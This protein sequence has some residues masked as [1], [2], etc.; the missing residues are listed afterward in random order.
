MISTV[1]IKG[2]I[3]HTL[4]K[5]DAT[6]DDF[7][8]LLQEAIDSQMSYVCVPGTR[9]QQAISMAKEST[10]KVAAV[11]GFPHGNQLDGVKAF[12]TSSLVKLGVMEIDMVIDIGRLKE[13]DYK[14]VL[15]DIK[16]V[17]LAA[18]EQG[19]D[20]IIKV[21]I[22]TCLLT[23]EQIIDACILS[24]L[25]GADYVKTSTGF[26]SGGAK[27]EDIVLMK[28]VVGDKLLVK[29]SGGIKTY[30]DAI[31]MLQSGASRIGT[32]S[33]LTIINK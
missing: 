31:N 21:I 15:E 25:G 19:E 30:S 14:Y 8:K 33:G 17:C 7:N 9:A 11:V 20:R 10:V 29:A 26:S 18:K 28:S 22:E 13:S 23:K 4:L 12:E 27:I 16:S 32:S 5:Q 24:A 3:D 2:L 6:T 1:D